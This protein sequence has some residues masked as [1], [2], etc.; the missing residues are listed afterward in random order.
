MFNR[1]I[2]QDFTAVF[3]ISA[4]SVAA[5]I[6]VA[7]TWRALRMGRPQIQRMENLPFVTPTPPASH[8]PDT[9]TKPG[10]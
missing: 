8:G 5:S 10:S 3:T 6:F 7:V 1:L 2:Y 9:D 4:F